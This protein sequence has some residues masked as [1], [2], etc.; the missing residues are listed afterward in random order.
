[1]GSKHILA[2][3]L[4]ATLLLFAQ[5]LKISGINPTALD[6][7]SKVIA[8]IVVSDVNGLAAQFKTQPKFYN[9]KI[10]GS[11]AHVVTL[12]IN[13]VKLSGRLEGTLSVLYFRGS[14]AS[15]KKLVESPYVQTAY[16]KIVPEIPPKDFL[17]EVRDIAKELGGG[18]LPTL[19]VMREIIGASTVEQLFG[20]NGTGVIIAVVDTGVDYGHPDLQDAMA[21]LIRTQSGEIIASTISVS[22]TSLVYKTLR[23]QTVAIPLSQIVSVEPLVLDADESQVIILTPMAAVGGLLPTAGTTFYVVD[24]VDLYSVGA[25]CNYAVSGLISKS[26]VYKFGMTYQ[27]IP[28]YGGYVSV[29]VVMYDPDQPGVYTAA[30]VD[31][32]NDCNFGDDPELKYFGNRLIVNNPTAPT[33]S[34]GVAGGY[35]YDWGLWF[36]PHAGFYPGW[37]LSGSYLSIFYDFN[38]HGTAC[39]S[40]AAGRGKVAYNLALLGQQRLRGI[41]PGAKILGVKGLWW[42]MVEPGMMWVAG[43]DVN[44]N[45]QWYWTGQ[46]RAHIISNSWGIST[47]IYDFAA[48]GYDLESAFLNALATPGYLDRNYPGIVIVHAGGNGGYGFGTI[49]SPGAALGVITVGAAT[50]GHYWWALGTPFRDMRFGDVISWSLRGPTP[51]GYVKPDVVNIGAFGVAAYPVGWGS[52]F[53]NS[54][55]DWDIFG[56]T[57]Q[58]TPLTAGVVALVLSSV[59]DK[60]DP[61]KVDP[62]WVKSIITST[63]KDIGYTPFTAGHGFVDATSAVIAARTWYGLSAPKAPVALFTTN[64][65][66]DLGRSWDFQWRVNIPLYFGYLLNNML[67]TQ[68]AS[69]LQYGFRQPTIPMT[70]LYLTVVPGGTATGQVTV[71]STGYALSVKA[72]AVALAPI[73][74]KTLTLNIPVGTLGGYFT[75]QQ[76]G[77]DENTIKSAD[78]VVF[79]MAY[80]FKYFDPE[81]NY[82]E[83]TRPVLWVL[84]WIDNGDNVPST[85]ELIWYNY[86]YQR[87]TAVEVPVARL[88]ARMAPNERLLLRIDVRPVRI[89]YPST[90]PVVLEVVAYKRVPAP[91]VQVVPSS[92][93]LAPRQSYVFVVRVTAPTNAAPTAYERMILFDINGTTYIVPLSYVVRASVSVN[94]DLSLTSGKTDSWYNASELRGGDDWNWRYE[95]GDWRVYYISTPTLPRGVFADFRW[96][97]I[98]TSL[99]VYTLTSDGLFA[100]YFWNQGVSYHSFLGS[101][102]FYWTG[103]AG[104]PR[105]VILASSSFA[106]PI[107]V[108]GYAYST[109]SASYPVQ[110]SSS[111]TILVRTSLYGGCTTSERITGTVRPFISPGDTPVSF[112]T[113]PFVRIALSTPPVP[114]NFAIKFAT[115]MGGGFVVPMFMLGAD[116]RFNM[117]FIRLPVFVDYVALLYSPQYATVYR[118]G[119]NNYGSYPFYAIEGV[120]IT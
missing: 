57:S 29:G 85:S 52:Y 116:L 61:A 45:G 60:Q 69:Y 115:V 36:G 89:P 68:W 108:N 35:F 65:R 20:V 59:I 53:Y 39:S 12:E 100:G 40:V 18:P 43:F 78:L 21:W 38:S 6:T 23:G 88:G 81:F 17:S 41:S 8:K 114:Y 73:Y 79:R 9:V 56:G 67:T 91:D 47:F 98:N 66:V 11:E 120:S 63:A 7:D 1:M 58:A 28:W 112:T 97:C 80:N 109:M 90:V 111:F 54:P 49:T 83:N 84:G 44:Q 50:S 105:I 3:L 25:T 30:R 26:G 48:F 24:G 75:M 110:G 42:G 119:G 14:A 107:T 86:G 106:T 71:V 62:H 96:S 117:Y 27:Y 82:F 104:Q 33:I 22:G 113:S 34:L 118:T 10:M 31:I 32:N 51:A 5:S 74:R 46:K 2:V 102:K 37:D 55:E 77:I 15:L 13:G 95:S 19:P 94:R 103:T 64:S 99:I 76:L 72:S 16:V 4:F 92:Y 101:G 70:S 93:T 87:G